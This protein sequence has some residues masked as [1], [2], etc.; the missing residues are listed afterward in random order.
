MMNN[1]LLFYPQSFTDT[2]LIS[3]WLQ[4]YVQLVPFEVAKQGLFRKQTHSP[5]PALP[6]E[7]VTYSHIIL[8]YKKYKRSKIDSVYQKIA[9]YLNA[10]KPQCAVSIIEI[11]T[12]K[13]INTAPS[14]HI[15]SARWM[16]YSLTSR[17]LRKDISSKIALMQF[18]EEFTQEHD[19]R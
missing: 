3:S 7:L 18:F 10:K 5:L 17:E 6:Q 15:P 2:Q 16:F 12:A 1:I 9:E 4:P 14:L 8:L 11:T 13:E 19:Y